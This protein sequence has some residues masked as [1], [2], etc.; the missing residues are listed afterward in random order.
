[1]W[2]SKW[3]DLDFSGSISPP[4]GYA[5]TDFDNRGEK[6]NSDTVSTTNNFLY[7]N[8]GA[9]VQL[10]AFGVSA[11]GDFIRYD[12][13]SP[14]SEG[15]SSLQLTL[16]RIHL[17]GAYG[18]FDNQLV[19]GGGARIVFVNIDERASSGAVI[20]M[21]GA[22]PEAGIVVKPN[23]V[24]WRIGA[25]VRSAVEASDLKTGTTVVDPNTGARLAAG[26][27]TPRSITQPW[28][29]EAGVA[30]QLGPRPL[31]PPWI[32][33]SDDELGVT[34][35]AQKKQLLA[36]RKARYQNWPRERVLLLASAV[37]TGPSTDAVALEGFLEQKREIVGRHIGVSPR[38]AAESEPIPNL[39]RLRTGVYLEPSRFDYGTAR[40]HF[41]FGG[42][43]RIF[44]WDLFGLLPMTTLRISGFF[45]V[46]ARYYN[47]G[48][49]LGVW[50]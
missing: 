33:P 47:Y 35:P 6:A 36:R 34:D 1:M 9:Q 17:V 48:G 37:M 46:S 44:A 43:V 13:S 40:Q 23:D 25:T 5:G 39:L 26:F 49:G 42:D 32:N 20:S 31:N 14:A 19:V 27:V 22:A 45:D 12:V 3:V 10:G 15:G 30:F 29:V 38:F 8:L 24:P 18:L 21:V 4:G 28:E 50:H 11:M 41:T 7:Y 2:S 16:G